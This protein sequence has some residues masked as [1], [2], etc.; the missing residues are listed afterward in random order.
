MLFSVRTVRRV[1]PSH[2]EHGSVYHVS[3]PAQ[4]EYP[5]TGDFAQGVND[6]IVESLA[7][8]EEHRFIPQAARCDTHILDRCEE[9]RSDLRTTT[10][11]KRIS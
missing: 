11:V 3:D 8:G 9:L 4:I 7:V 6:S 5:L 2:V 1:S 10:I